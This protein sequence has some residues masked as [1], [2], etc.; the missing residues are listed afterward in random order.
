MH[1]WFLFANI[2]VHD[3]PFGV[4]LLLFFA[5]GLPPLLLWT[6]FVTLS[7]AL[8]FVLL[9]RHVVIGSLQDPASGRTSAILSILSELLQPL[10]W[11]HATLQH[12][13]RWRT[14]RIAL[15]ADGTFSYIGGPAS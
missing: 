10:H 13:L 5:L 15:G 12:T 7:Y 6:G 1:R 4:Q 14:R 11:L 2:L 9:L 8:P 3:Q